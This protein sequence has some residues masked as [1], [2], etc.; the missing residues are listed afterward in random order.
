MAIDQKKEAFEEGRRAAY[1][2]EAL[3]MY[4]PSYHRRQEL[5]K[6]FVRGYTSVLQDRHREEMRRLKDVR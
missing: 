3:N 6:E 5:W 4:E 2:N 1:A